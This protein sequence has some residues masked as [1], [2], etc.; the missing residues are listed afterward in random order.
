MTIESAQQVIDVLPI[1]R[2]LV[3]ADAGAALAQLAQPAVCWAAVVV[4]A[5]CFA[6]LWLRQFG[7]WRLTYQNCR[8]PL[9]GSGGTV[10]VPFHSDGEDMKTE[11]LALA[12]ACAL[13]APLAAMAQTAPVLAATCNVTIDYSLNG[14]AVEPHTEQFTVQ[15]GVPYENDF[16]TPTRLKVLNADLVRNGN[17]A[18]VLLSYFNDVGTFDAIRLDT[19]LVLK[20]RGATESAAARQSHE[21]SGSIPGSHVVNWSFSCRGK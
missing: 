17:G 14:N 18:T 21:V 4:S 8:C 2:R 16:S 13:G 10:F 15:E 7:A 1:V 5:G 11:I 3:L 9:C 6:L 20:R 12:L 19:S